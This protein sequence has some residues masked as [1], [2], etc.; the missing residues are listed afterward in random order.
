MPTGFVQLN[1]AST[2]SA[3]VFTCD[4]SAQGITCTVEVSGEL[5]DFLSGPAHTTE[6]SRVSGTD[7]KET[8][9]VRDNIPMSIS[10]RRFIR[11]KVTK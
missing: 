7:N 11:L 9:I 10:A 3:I 6:V 5:I 8:V 4:K 2:Y 1:G